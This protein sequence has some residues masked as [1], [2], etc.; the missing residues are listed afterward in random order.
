MEPNFNQALFLSKLTY[1]NPDDGNFNAFVESLLMVIREFYPQSQFQILIFNM[2]KK[3]FKS[4]SLNSGKLDFRIHPT[5]E[6]LHVENSQ[7]LLPQKSQVNDMQKLLLPLIKDKEKIG[8]IEAVG[9]EFCSTLEVNLILLGQFIVRGM[10]SQEKKMAID[11]LVELNIEL[12]KIVDEKTESLL[13]EK[14]AHFHASK[15]ATLGEIAA[16]IAHEINNPL[17]IIQVRILTIEKQMLKKNIL[18]SEFSESFKKVVDTIQRINKIIKGLKFISRDAHIDPPAKIALGQLFETTFDL[19]LEK[20]KMSQVV[21]IPDSSE[22]DFEVE[23][24]ETQIVQVL[25]NLIN[26]AFDAVKNLPEKWIQIEYLTNKDNLMIK[27]KD[28]GSG[29][30]EDILEKIMN[31][32]FTTKPAGQGTGLGLSISKGIIE[33]HAGKLYYNGKSSNTEFIIEIPYIR[34]MK[35]KATNTVAS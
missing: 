31:P 17:T 6:S 2:R 22:Y 28:S 10:I 24:R 33:N 29:I 1:L 11:S 13:K 19:C 30:P 16:G 14:E 27:I 25:L 20:L 4:Y 35:K 34:K 8:Y 3:N 7:N 32:F 9:K 23:V 5:L 21:L 18:D 15:M 12:E 26:N